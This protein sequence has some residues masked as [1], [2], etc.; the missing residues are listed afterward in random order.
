MKTQKRK[1]KTDGDCEYASFSQ[2]SCI[3]VHGLIKKK[4]VHER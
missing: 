2:Y 1:L 4:K 3:I